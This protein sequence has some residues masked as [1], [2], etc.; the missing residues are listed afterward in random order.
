MAEFITASMTGGIFSSCG[1]R[2]ATYTPNGGSPVSCTVIFEP[3]GESLDLT[4]GDVFQL[5]DAVTFQASEVSQPAKDAALV[6]TDDDLPG[7]YLVGSVI[8][9]D[10]ATVTVEVRK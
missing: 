1:G 9:R 2:S 7:T 8:E 4:T 10:D 3:G 6:F 5:A